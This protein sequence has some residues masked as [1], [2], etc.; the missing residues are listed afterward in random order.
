ML[1]WKPHTLLKAFDLSLQAIEENKTLRFLGLGNNNI[2]EE[3]CISLVHKLAVNQSLTLLD[4][5]F[6]PLGEW[7]PFVC[8]CVQSE[9]H[10]LAH[11]VCVT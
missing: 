10:C 2:R 9:R 8:V 7:A 6:N 4:L 3:G 1:Y 5:S 11:S